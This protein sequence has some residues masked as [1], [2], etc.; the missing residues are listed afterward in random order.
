MPD[1]LGLHEV[2]QQADRGFCDTDLISWLH[3]CRWHYR[4]RIKSSL[5]LAAPDG[6]RLCKVSEIRLAARETRCFHNVTV[7]AQHFG[8]VHLALGRPTDS[9]EQ[10]QVVS[11]EPTSIETLTEYGERFQIEDGFLDG[12]SGLFALES[13]RIRNAAGLERLIPTLSVAALLLVSEGLQ[14]VVAGVRRVIDPH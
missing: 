8:L 10:W 9:A 4:I 6:Q 11:D 5:I 14:V 7:T 12:R 2:R 3:V 13:S 1:F